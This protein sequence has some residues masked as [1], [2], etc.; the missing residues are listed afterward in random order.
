M[1]FRWDEFDP[2]FNATFGYGPLD[3]FRRRFERVF[4]DMD[5]EWRPERALRPVFADRGEALELTA[6]IPGV[7]EKDVTLTLNQDVL[8]LGL[9]RTVTAPEG[10]R[11][12]RQERAG[13]QATRSYALPCRIDPEKVRANLKDGILTVRLG[14]AAEAVPRRV[15]VN[16]E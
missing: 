1:L 13:F 4:E 12:H 5:R 14:K 2:S 6:E 7:S 3:E 9:K 10:Y 11:P 16:A 8:T 15:T